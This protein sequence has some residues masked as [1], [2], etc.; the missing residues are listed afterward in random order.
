MAA[1]D[2][3]NLDWGDG[4][5]NGPDESWNPARIRPFHHHITEFVDGKV[6]FSGQMVP[7]ATGATGAA[8]AV[9]PGGAETHPA[10]PRSRTGK[11]G[12]E[13]AAAARP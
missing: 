6:L 5:E 11:A 12:G 3:T 13:P 4:R 2:R 10:M 1:A 9:P 7:Q 8:S